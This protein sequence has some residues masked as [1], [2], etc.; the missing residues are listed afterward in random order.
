M[1]VLCVQIT[2]VA[3]QS[4]KLKLSLMLDNTQK[5]EWLVGQTNGLLAFKHVNEYT[6]A[7]GFVEE[8]LKIYVQ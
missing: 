1:P 2:Q 7:C 3:L 8:V 4:S 6:A 5:V